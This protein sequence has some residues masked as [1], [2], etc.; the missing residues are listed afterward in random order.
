MPP[1][2]IALPVGITFPWLPSHPEVTLDA[3]QALREK[4]ELI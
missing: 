3:R 4:G 1:L 2:L